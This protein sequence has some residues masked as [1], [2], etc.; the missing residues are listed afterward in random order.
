MLT[1]LM[2]SNETGG[3]ISMNII[4]SPVIVRYT[5]DDSF[6]LGVATNYGASQKPENLGVWIVSTILVPLSF[7]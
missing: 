1:Q 6:L 5:T 2:D 4:W 7:S 3:L